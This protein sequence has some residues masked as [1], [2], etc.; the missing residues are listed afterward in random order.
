[1]RN[2]KVIISRLESPSSW[3]PRDWRELTLIA[4]ISNHGREGQGFSIWLYG[5]IECW[6]HNRIAVIFHFH[7]PFRREKEEASFLWRDLRFRDWWCYCSSLYLPFK[8]TFLNTR[9]FWRTQ[10][11]LNHSSPCFHEDLMWIQDLS[12][13]NMMYPKKQF[14]TVWPFRRNPLFPSDLSCKIYWYAKTWTLWITSHIFFIIFSALAM[15]EQYFDFR[16]SSPSE[17]FLIE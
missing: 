10:W 8:E 16:T 12:I 2:P 1:M 5:D 13:I 14:W 17:I 15:I 3:H 11:F 6:Y 7:L 9:E 4:I